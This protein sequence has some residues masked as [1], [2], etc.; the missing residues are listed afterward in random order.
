MSQV[1]AEVLDAELELVR[2]LIA[3]CREEQQA[4]RRD[5]LNRLITAVEIKKKLAVELA[6]VEKRRL[7][8][9]AELGAGAEIAGRTGTG[10]AEKK[11][12]LVK[13]LRELKEINSTNELLIRQSLAYA[14]RMLALLLPDGGREAGEVLFSRTV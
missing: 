4:L 5:D 12:D 7:E 3:A 11:A 10:L 1:L 9:Q 8:A 13:A 6:A 14:R 2:D